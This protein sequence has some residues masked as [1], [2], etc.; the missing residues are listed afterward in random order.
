MRDRLIHEY[1]GV[2]YKIVWKTVKEEI[3]ELEEN[4][5]EI[6]KRESFNYEKIVTEKQ[7]FLPIQSTRLNWR[8]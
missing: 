5:K 8:M 6:F 1:F 3:P 4:I 2:N 7:I